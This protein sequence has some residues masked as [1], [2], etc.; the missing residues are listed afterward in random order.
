MKRTIYQALIVALVLIYPALRVIT[1][2]NALFTALPTL[3]FVAFQGFVTYLYNR[4]KP[5]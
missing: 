1:D 5:A 2:W 4:V 3:S